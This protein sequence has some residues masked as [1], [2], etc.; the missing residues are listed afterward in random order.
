MSDAPIF[1]PTPPVGPFSPYAPQNATPGIE[2]G[3]S[4]RRLALWQP[5]REHVNGL[6]RESGDTVVARARW[7]VRNNGYARAALRSWSTA[8]VGPGI[9]PSPQLDD[10]ELKAAVALAWSDWTDAA[11]AEGL[12]DFY[13]I[14]LRVAREVFLAGECFVRFIDPLPEDQAVIPLQIQVLASE[15]LPLWRQVYAPNGNQVRLGIEFDRRNRRVAYWFWKENP[16]DPTLG[17]EMALAAQQLMRV[18]ADE[19]LHVFDPVEAGQIRGL[20]GFA[21]AI[22]KL[23]MLDV[24]DDAELERKKQAARFATFVTKPPPNLQDP[25]VV[26]ET[27]PLTD[28]LPPY[29]GP[30]AFME[31]RDGEDVKFSDPADVGANYEAFQFRTLLQIASALGVPYAELTGDLT[32]ASYA[33]S[34]AGLLAFR[35]NVEAY[36]FAVLVYQFLR[37]IYQRWLDKAVLAGAVPILA[38]SYR[39]N[40]TNLQRFRAMTPKAPWVDPM[41]DRQAEALAVQNGFKSRSD[42]V[43][44]EGF[45]PEENDARIA[46]DHERE[47]R[48]GLNFTPSPK[49][50][51]SPPETIDGDQAEPPDPNNPDEDQQNQEQAA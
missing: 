16:T 2:A 23:F 15:Q 51:T 1:P 12:T 49:L 25:N 29:Y 6:L 8:T 21:A 27:D 3:A 24:Y 14:T 26:Y 18:P 42:V 17:W 5:V 44:A 7:L 36:Q 30:G 20:S 31:L 28:A 4:R 50:A 19:I 46:A 38:R 13:G 47:R 9:K 32:K 40:R 37:P 10:P 43:E 11:D 22:V 48:L 34:R 33:S 41:K 35:G 45:D 39:V